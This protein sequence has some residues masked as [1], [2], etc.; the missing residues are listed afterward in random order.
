MAHG[1]HDYGYVFQNG[2]GEDRDSETDEV[3][4]NV[5]QNDEFQPDEV[6][7]YYQFLRISD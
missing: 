7:T 2:H 5:E 3:Q 4:D 6:C 1:E